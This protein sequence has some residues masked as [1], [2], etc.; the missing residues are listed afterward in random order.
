MAQKKKSKST[1]RKKTTTALI[2]PAGFW[3]DNWLPALIIFVLP[4]LFYFRTVNYEYVLDDQI[5]L[6]DNDFTKKGLDGIGDLLS[7][8]SMAGYFGEQKDLV[9][10]GRYRPLS[11]ITFA[12]EYEFFGLNPWVNHFVNIVFY[13]LCCLLLFRILS[14]LLPRKNTHWWLGLPFVASLLFALHPVHVEV[15]A[16]IKGRDEV[17][18]LIGALGALYFSLVYVA[19]PKQYYWLFAASISFFLGILAKENALTFLAV[20][21]LALYFFTEASFKTI[22]IVTAPLL[23]VILIY[24]GIRTSIIGYLLDSGKEVTGIM[25]NPFFGMYL[26]EKYATIFYTLGQYLKL[27]FFPHPLTHDYYPYHI[28]VMNWGDFSVLLSFLLYLA[29]GIYALFGLGKKR[30]VSFSI[31]F[32]IITLSIVSNLFFPVGTFMNERFLFVSSV[33]VCIALAYFISRWPVDF[34]DQNANLLNVGLLA[35]YVLFFSF[36]TWTR[37]PVWENPLTLNAAAVEVSENS[38]RANCMMGS[39]LFEKYKVTQSPEVKVQL[40]DEALGFFN[41]A[42]RIYP[43]YYDAQRMRAGVAAEHYKMDRDVDKMLNVFYDVL[44]IK[45]RIDFIDEYMDYLKRRAEQGAVPNEKLGNF[46]YRIG[47]DHFYVKQ[48]EYDFAAMYLKYGTEVDPNSARLWAAL[49]KA[50]EKL[51]YAKQAQACYNKAVQLDP[52]LAN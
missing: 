30:V 23:L 52:T 25:N 44:T 24:L 48:G 47:Y 51:N 14:I 5:V 40:L 26:S 35:I 31:L 36:K 18:T 4:F 37:V 2:I 50:Y 3:K 11:I 13:S 1:K 46:A 8:E 10:G 19:K 32:F 43:E 49:G 12:I 29:L 39:A 15:V 21:P 33:G 20:I 9:V 45:K 16:N 41:K 7:T 38:A 27:S 6:S 17:L 28:P 34:T 42:I 22:S